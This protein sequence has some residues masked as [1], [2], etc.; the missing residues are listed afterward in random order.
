MSNPVNQSVVTEGDY[1]PT[2]QEKHNPTWE[3]GRNSNK[4]H[5]EWQNVEAVDPAHD[6]DVKQWKSAAIKR[7]EKLDQELKLNSVQQQR[8]LQQIMAFSAPEGIALRIGDRAVDAADLSFHAESIED[9]IL[10]ALDTDRA[11][12][13]QQSLIDHAAWWDHAIEQME[14]STMEEE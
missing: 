13:Y 6:L 4:G 1:Y 10:E 9:A 14:T 5:R 7:V 3:R 8:I 12:L 11:R 2:S